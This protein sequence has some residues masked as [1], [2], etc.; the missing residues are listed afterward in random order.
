MSV[1][2]PS[3]AFAIV[4]VALS[5][6]ACASTKK[7]EGTGEYVDDSV[8]T[9][10]VKTELLRD[11][12]VSGF[13]VNVETFKGIVQLSGFVDNDAQRQHAVDDA[14]RVAGVKDVKDSIQIR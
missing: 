9:S 14:R 13:A 6:L 3:R 2:R 8:V 5:L 10:K 4:V 11:R 12:N 1:I 7:Q